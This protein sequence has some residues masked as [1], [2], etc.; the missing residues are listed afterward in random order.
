MRIHL[1]NVRTGLGC[2]S[3]IMLL[4]QGYATP[5][6]SL[7]D[8]RNIPEELLE[9]ANAVIRLH[10]GNVE[11]LNKEKGIITIT[12][13]VTILNRSG[14]G[15]NKV[16]AHYDSEFSKITDIQ[17]ILYDASGKIIRK[18]KGKDIKDV[19]TTSFGVGDSRA[20]YAEMRDS[21]YPYT[22][23]Y[24][25]T[26]VYKGSLYL[27]NWIF[28]QSTNASVQESF[29]SIKSPKEVKWRYKLFNGAPDPKVIEADGEVVYKWSLKGIPSI[30]KE[31][32]SPGTYPPMVLTNPEKL[33]WGGYE[34]ASS[35][36]EEFGQF[37]YNLNKDRQTLPDEL[38]VQVQEMTKEASSMAEK[39]D[40]LYQYMQE[41]TRYVS[42]QLGIG[43]WQTFE[44]KYVFANGYGDCKALTNYLHAMLKEVDIT[45]YPVL[46]KAGRKA[47]DIR[48]DFVADQFNHVI[49][50][51]V[52]EGDTIWVE[53]TST[54]NP[55]GYLGRFTQDR[56]ALL[57]KDG[58]SKIVKTPVA[59]PTDNLQN[60]KAEIVLNVDG[61]AEAEVSTR[62]TGYQQDDIRGYTSRLNERDMEKWIKAG[63]MIPSF[64]LDTYALT[65]VK[66]ERLP[67]YELTYEVFAR[68]WAAAT[69]SRLFLAPNIL[70]PRPNVPE[71][72][73]NRTQPI[74]LEYPYLDT[75]TL[76]YHL[77]EGYSIESM[78]EMPVKIETVF[79]EY[80]A[81]IQMK[82]LST[83]VYTRKLKMEKIE[84]PA[85][86]YE[87]YRE[88]MKEVSSA[89]KLQIVLNG[90]S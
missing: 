44:P 11:I 19:S 74:S 83:L 89:D 62:F 37:S 17:G 28:Q 35:T 79:G 39:V 75:D 34:G 56:H 8:V 26:R 52:E 4:V 24:S 90:K 21:K 18:L 6:P 16:V 25:Y 42:V 65:E 87:A 32:L 3:L 41:N 70:N 66:G 85:K 50:A 80:E 76:T 38:K 78:P 13:A 48:T 53:C 68:K 60:R 88:F 31:Y 51:V 23:S 49:L 14:E 2:L 84:L 61:T 47:K 64:D 22:V 59:Y 69:G 9:N 20:K 71:K 77:P 82:D 72:M 5:I 7:F 30:K 57:Y 73:E 86:S 12:Q 15:Y 29:F 81:N 40:I 58:G 36:W 46:V 1:G 27:P 10:T 43:G 63:I 33:V 67:T 54:D 55:A 45:S